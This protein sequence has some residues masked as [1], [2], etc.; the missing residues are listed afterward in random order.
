[1]TYNAPRLCA[2]RLRRT[3]IFWRER[4]LPEQI[5]ICGQQLPIT[6]LIGPLASRNIHAPRHCIMHELLLKVSEASLSRKREAALPKGPRSNVDAALGRIKLSVQHALLAISPL[7][8]R[9]SLV[10]LLETVICYLQVSKHVARGSQPRCHRANARF[11]G[12]CVCVQLLSLPI[13]DTA[14]MLWR[15][16]MLENASSIFSH[17]TVRTM[18][19]PSNDV[20][21]LF[22]AIGWSILVAGAF[23]FLGYVLSQE[24]QPP[25]WITSVRSVSMAIQHT[26]CRACSAVVQTSMASRAL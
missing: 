4:Q 22:I 16:T 11:K 12:L 13:Y 24:R 8:A 7:S 1:M 2:G 5:Q 6:Q 15:L 3:L 10:W 18:G 23:G 26:T 21:L 19:G 25:P 14:P 20:V 9:S 17:V